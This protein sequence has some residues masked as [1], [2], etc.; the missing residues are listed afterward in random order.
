M[1]VMSLRKARQVITLQSEAV[2]IE[3][4]PRVPNEGAG[5]VAAHSSLVV[6]WSFV[7]QGP[8]GKRPLDQDAELRKKENKRLTWLLGPDSRR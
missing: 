2:G 8:T 3:I 6:Q 5:L 4:D 1:S 7:N